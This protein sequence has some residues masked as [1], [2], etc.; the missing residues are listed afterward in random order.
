MR[1]MFRRGGLALILSLNLG[2]ATIAQ[3][4]PPAQPPRWVL[5]DDV[6]VRSGPSP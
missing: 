6:R 2:L 1:H 4:A 5:A 3:A